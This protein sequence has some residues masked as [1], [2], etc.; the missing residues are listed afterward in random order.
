MKKDRQ[1]Y[2]QVQNILERLL[3]Y[4]E[5]QSG[6]RLKTHRRAIEDI[7]QSLANKGID[8]LQE[9]AFLRFMEQCRNFL[10]E[11]IER[12][13][14]AIQQGLADPHPSICGDTSTK[15][16]MTL[17]KGVSSVETTLS[18]FDKFEER[19]GRPQLKEL[20]D[21]LKSE[22]ANE[23]SLLMQVKQLEIEKFIELVKRA[24]AKRLQALSTY[25]DD[26]LRWI[27]NRP[28]LVWCS[29]IISGIGILGGLSVALHPLKE[30]VCSEKPAFECAGSI[31]SMSKK[32]IVHTSSEGNNK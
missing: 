16:H 19:L 21:K 24:E 28:L 10:Q 18:Y 2:V 25:F 13:W 14:T 23:R 27:K 6:V 30:W 12:T 5:N 7:H 1:H 20:V 17:D 32:I 11:D 3:P 4:L 26:K 22:I 8:L 15:I 9:Q 29:L 31:W